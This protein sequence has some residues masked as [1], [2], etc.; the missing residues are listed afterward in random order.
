MLCAPCLIAGRETEA[1]TQIAGT[2]V[3]PGCAM[4]VS[5]A[6]AAR[7]D[8]VLGAQVYAARQEDRELLARSQE[9]GVPVSMLRDPG[10]S[11]DD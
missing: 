6:P 7:R 5:Q 2:L 1:K 3:C 9:L 11:V 10:F 8:T 4:L